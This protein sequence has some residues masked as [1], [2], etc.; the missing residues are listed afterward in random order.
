MKSVSWVRLRLLFEEA[1]TLPAEERAAYLD[2]RCPDDRELRVEVERLL[3]QDSTQDDFLEPIGGRS[4]EEVFASERSGEQL[5]VPGFVVGQVIARGGMGVVYEA[6]QEHPRRKVALKTLRRRDASDDAMSRLRREA[7]ILAR[8][9]H[10]NVAAVYDAGSFEQDGE[11]VPYFAMEFV[12]GARD[13]LAYA[14]EAALGLGE[15]VELAATVCDAVAHGHQKGVIHRD[16]KPGNVLVDE[17]G[18]VKVIDFGLARAQADDLWSVSLAET[19]HGQVLGSLDSMS[20]E[21]VSGRPSDVDARSDVYSLC[22]VFCRLLTGSPPLEL[23][24]VSLVE[25]AR[26]IDE[27]PPHV[28]SDLDP[29]LRWVLARGLAKD[30]A[31]RYASVAELAAELRR[32]LSG[33]PVLAGPPS[34]SRR[35]RGLVRRHRALV[36]GAAAVL[37][38]IAFGFLRE[39]DARREAQ[40]AEVRAN[41][42]MRDTLEAHE[43]FEAMFANLYGEYAAGTDG[44]DFVA[45]F[46]R[47]LEHP[48]VESFLR[49]SRPTRAALEEIL[50]RLLREEG[51]VDEAERHFRA[52]NATLSQELGPRD[53]LV[54][55]NEIQLCDYPWMA[56]RRDEAVERMQDLLPEYEAVI[57]IHAGQIYGTRR[58][59][60][61]RLMAMGEPEHAEA[62]ARETFERYLTKP[63]RSAGNHEQLWRDLGLALAEQERY[64]ELAVL[65]DDLVAF[66]EAELGPD[67]RRTVDNV[68]WAMRIHR[69]LWQRD[70]SAAE[71]DRAIELARE[72]WQRM[73]RA[74]SI[75]LDAERKREAAEEY[76]QLLF[77]AER[78]ADSIEPWL[79]AVRHA[80]IG[81]A[82]RA[83]NAWQLAHARL[84]SGDP[85]SAEAGLVEVLDEY[86]DGSKTR[87]SLEGRLAEAWLASGRA[88]EAHELFT[89]LV[90]RASGSAP[91]EVLA[92]W[93]EGAQRAAEGS[94]GSER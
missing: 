40:A 44:F 74:G 51:R 19:A 70:G 26:R 73:E 9:S 67:D 90:E 49:H 24:G 76:G 16:L 43:A 41:E 60:Y 35:L 69:T 13:L 91:E 68:Q 75:E 78:F 11:A 46:E 50:A 53:P 93:R 63:G 29:E 86:P 56:G 84:E 87:M 28:A 52:A 42:R 71:L 61:L 33:E 4:L 32:F 22:A 94:A 25:A 89:S 10:P 38:A 72:T 34:L 79:A 85:E 57:G 20:P 23:T 3:E 15:R 2:S 54:L 37:V 81:H 7:E 6:Y 47:S 88:A 92:G 66:C 64:A 18:R 45:A 30:P 62:L 31:E 21:H 55:H 82:Q 1:R 83:S 12:E 58:V 27:E 39:R 65:C 36:L 14:H 48:T 80:E 8:L 77:A 5:D 59:L 17:Q